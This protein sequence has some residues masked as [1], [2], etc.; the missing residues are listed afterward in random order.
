MYKDTIDAERARVTFKKIMEYMKLPNNRDSTLDKE[1][2]IECII[3]LQQTT[4]LPPEEFVLQLV[5]QTRKCPKAFWTRNAW[6][7]FG[8]LLDKMENVNFNEV[9]SLAFR[10]GRFILDAVVLAFESC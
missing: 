8:L 9:R 6:K 2:C 7:L 3:E 4:G 5:K 1:G 10:F